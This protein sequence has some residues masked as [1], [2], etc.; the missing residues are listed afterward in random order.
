LDDFG[1]GYS[2]LSYLPEL[3]FTSIKLDRSF[4]SKL[5]PGSGFNTMIRSMVDLAH[6]LSMRVIVEGVE[7]LTQLEL[8]KELGADEVQGYLLGRPGPNPG[9]RLRP[10][11]E[12]E[13]DPTPRSTTPAY[14]AW[15]AEQE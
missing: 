3:P 10:Q 2:C 13:A 9:L 6:S 8:V 1:T 15:T 11:K 4:V 14:Q 7:H 12:L 5:S